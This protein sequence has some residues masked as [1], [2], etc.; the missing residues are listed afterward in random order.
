[1]TNINIYGGGI[2]GL[3]IAHELA[4]KGFKITIYEK[5]NICGG[6]ARSL[7]DIETNIPSEHSWRGYGPFYYNLFKTLKEIPIANKNDNLVI[8]NYTNKKSNIYTIDDIEKHN[9]INDLW[10]YYQNDVYDL[11]EF[12][13]NH[14]GG[15]IIGKCA[16]KNLTDVWAKFGVSWH[17]DNSH[18]LSILKKYK[19]GKLIENYSQNNSQNNSQ[20]KTYNINS[21]TVYDNLSHNKLNFG[22]LYNSHNNLKK[23]IKIY[24]YPYIIYLF[25]KV[26][27]SNHR[28]EKYFKVN[29]NN[30]IKNIL[31][32]Q[33]YHYLADFLAGP[34]FGFDKNTISLAHFAL[35]TEFNYNANFQSWSVMN[36]PTNESFIDPWV[37]HL[38]KLGV[39]FKY[40]SSL[41]HI[42]YNN[43]TIDYCI[44]N[45]DKVYSSE[46]IIAL[47]PFEF[48][49]V[50]KKSNLT[51]Y[52]SDYSSLNTINNQISFRIGFTRKIDITGKNNEN[53][54]VLIDSP[55]N[56]TF[57][58]QE[59][60]WD[61]VGNMP[62]NNLGKIN[63]K[64]IKSL[65]SGTCILPYNNGII[66][67]KSATSLTISQLK[68][69]I[70]AQILSSNDLLNLVNDNNNITL[71]TSD[72]D[73]IE[74]FEDWYYDSKSKILK[75]KNKKWVNNFYNETYRPNNNTIFN[76]LYVVGSHTKT[77]V[78]IWSME[79]ACES[80]KLGTNLIL[81]K[82]NKQL[83]K[84]YN[85]DSTLFVKF[86]QT[87]DDILYKIYLPN[88]LDILVILI[89][90]LLLTGLYIT[91]K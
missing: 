32:S 87:I 48:E 67:G 1:M 42:V 63:D 50:I 23:G 7:R 71:T 4:K 64:P 15:N 29:F 25:L 12:V 22:L 24:D 55:Y 74:I 81:K 2:S 57:Y 36:N 61:N 83:I 21:S 85:H 41:T 79:G 66:Y 16:G 75:T 73:Y 88:I 45:G 26:I 78:N 51:D 49:N 80:G 14:P 54:Y 72:I 28:K 52:F 60:F 70:I 5:D 91:F 6:M 37:N 20:N 43:K 40:N 89:I 17:N 34:G 38:Q 9:T 19:I 76:N 69:E 59:D 90:I 35:F 10:T 18:V 68:K 53:S 84:I 13:K 30:K 39:K 47:N 77:S 8:E 82:Y 31:H 86:I 27:L 58:P 3:T 46:H 11:T 33:S 62:K 65:W 44:I 56:I